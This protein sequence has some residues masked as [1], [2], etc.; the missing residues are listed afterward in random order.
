LIAAEVDARTTGK[1][2]VDCINEPVC[3][4]PRRSDDDDE[5]LVEIKSG[6]KQYKGTKTMFQMISSGSAALCS[7]KTDNRS[8]TV[9]AIRLQALSDV[10]SDGL[11]SSHMSTDA[12]ETQTVKNLTTLHDL[13]M[14]QQSDYKGGTIWK[15]SFDEHRV[16]KLSRYSGN[17]VLPSVVVIR[18]LLARENVSNEGFRY[19]QVSAKQESS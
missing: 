7:V 15:L 14:N 13:F 17:D 3:K 5:V 6:K 19:S 2:L 4:K 11:P 12:L 16:L 1:Q 18:E 10:V 9:S 8:R